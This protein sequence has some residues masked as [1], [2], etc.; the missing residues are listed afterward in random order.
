[1]RPS[2]LARRLAPLAGPWALLAMAACAAAETAEAPG[3]LGIDV[4]HYS[5]AVDWERVRDAGFAFA[6][7][8][9]TEGV[10]DGD[11][12][13]AAHWRRL[14]ELGIPRGAYH[15][16]VTEDDPEE[17]ARFFL[18]TVEP[19]PGDLVPAVD[20]ETLGHGT[21]PGLDARLRTFL[22][23]IERAIGVRPVVY[24]SPK[25]WDA[26]LTDAFGEHHLWIADYGV[27]EP[28]LPRGWQRWSLWQWSDSHAVPGVEKDAD[29]SR[30]HPELT[31]EA[32]RIP[33]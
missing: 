31:L 32:L 15:F 13:F 20:V 3:A 19:R 18:A 33:E 30:L 2:I 1:M 23:T 14:G 4:S 16:Y 6:Y 10:D 7:V 8:K 25:F 11:P 29:L 5:G 12:A 27:D 28:A 24:T 21:Q 9:A 22:E 17:Q 26:H